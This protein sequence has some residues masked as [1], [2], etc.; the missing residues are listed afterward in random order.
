MAQLSQ[1]TGEQL[2][3]LD[4]SSANEHTKDRKYGWAPIGQKA[5]VS[6]IHK[7]SER[8]S[9]LP[10][11]TMHGYMAWRILHGSYTTELFNDFVREEVLPKCHPYPGPLSVIILDNASI[12]RNQVRFPM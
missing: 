6:T 5:A 8:W 4:E 11:Y 10:A 12:H 1:W 7:R 2:V 3:F 9:I